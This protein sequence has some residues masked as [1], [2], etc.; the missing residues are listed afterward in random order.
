MRSGRALLATTAT[1]LLASS[2]ACQK[3]Q[4]G[5][6]EDT[7]GQLPNIN[8]DLPP[9]PSFDPGPIPLTYPDG[10][11][12][13]VG[14][15]R[16]QEKYLG[17][18]V[19]VTAF[20]T[21]VYVCPPEIK[22]CKGTGCKNCEKPHFF[23]GDTADATDDKSLICSDYNEPGDKIVPGEPG[24]DNPP[25]DTKKLKGEKII[26]DAMYSLSSGAGFK[27]SDG[28]LGYKSMQDLS[29]PTAQQ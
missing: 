28:V 5:Y 24:S 8:V 6:G 1:L 15:K 16:R 17:Q 13:I 3:H 19:K 4:G 14:L 26:V 20:V 10:T 7:Q 11:L 23:V 2:F 29:S 25:L 21:D 12:S 9:V 18:E 22:N 27:S